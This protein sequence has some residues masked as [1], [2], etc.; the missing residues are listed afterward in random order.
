MTLREN[1]LRT[2]CVTVNLT[3][4]MNVNDY[5]LGILQINV[6]ITFKINF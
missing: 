2:V 4:L 5:L 6:Q 1:V 3:Y